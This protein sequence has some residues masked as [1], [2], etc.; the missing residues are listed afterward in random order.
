M[1]SKSERPP[2]F[3]DFPP[4]SAAEWEAQILKDLK[5]ADYEKKLVW[6]TMEGFRVRPYYRSEDLPSPDYLEEL[7]GLIK[8]GK[9][10]RGWIICQ[11][12]PLRDGV[13]GTLKRVRDALSGGARGIHLRLP[14]KVTGLSPLLKEL[15]E[16]V[17][18]EEA[19]LFFSGI[20]DYRSFMDDLGKVMEKSRIAPNRLKGSLGFDPVGALTVS[21]MTKD[22]ER[23]F[24][25]LPGILKENRET[26]LS[27]R[28]I[29]V[30]G[31]T[32]QDAGATLA[33]ELGYALSAGVETLDRLSENGLDP[34]A[35]AGTMQF[36][37]ATGPDYFMEI[38]KLRAARL[39][40]NRILEAYNISAEE[41]G[42][43]IHS[44]TASWNL[45]LYDP[46]VNILRATT[47][48]MSAA[49]GSA[50]VISVLPYDESYGK[51][52]SLSE[53]IARNIQV[54]LREEAYFDRV[55]N[56]AAGSYYIET[57]TVSLAGEAW[58]L[59]RKTEEEGG[60]AKSFLAGQVRKAVTG[61]LERHKENLASRRRSMIGTNQY[62]NFS[63]TIL[64]QLLTGTT[65]H[66]TAQGDSPVIRPV[67]ISESFEQVRLETEKSGKRPKVFMLKYGNQAWRI[68]RAL[69]ASN[70]FACAGY[71]I[72]DPPGV[73]DLEEGIEN[74]RKA[75][76]DIVVICS[77][78]D[79]Y[80]EIAPAIFKALHRRA[81][82]VVAGYP[83]DSVGQLEEAGI[84]HFIHVKSNLLETLQ[85]FNR[86]LLK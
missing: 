79:R 83:K 43:F 42:M 24:R 18:A 1:N 68:A 36:N 26:G 58:N 40:W 54:I 69:F 30:N 19:A 10:E 73:E 37:F 12:I 66:Y 38:A 2:L 67:R 55:A 44:T 61:S 76:P 32:F 74:A 39:L 77:S 86:I 5:G 59:F 4:V 51:T 72:L 75:S 15:L 78:D 7:H 8:K 62:P 35:I 33:Q 11:E 14:E 45:T 22:Y 31:R 9:E 65:E 27:M 13:S 20:I 41:R 6:N 50:N 82:I 29:A 3:S 85:A 64:D 60:Y 49:L 16:M 53:R 63:E 56:P 70:F 80:P 23:Q 25:M 48:T 57:L 28:T 84:R 17:T 52:T 34:A 46:H 47:E 71:E 81:E 21:G